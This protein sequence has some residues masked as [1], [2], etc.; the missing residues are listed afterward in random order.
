MLGDHVVKVCCA[1]CRPRVEN[2]WSRMVAATNANIRS[3][4]DVQK[5]KEAPSG[6]IRLLSKDARAAIIAKYPDGKVYNVSKSGSSWSIELRTAEGANRKI[7]V[8][9]DG[10]I[11]SDRPG[12]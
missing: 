3:S 5:T 7:Q 10:W 2:D 11:L 9:D 1:G 8:S 12:G 4:G 6:P